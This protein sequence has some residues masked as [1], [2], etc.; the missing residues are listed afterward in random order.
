MSSFG[1]LAEV[2]LVVFLQSVMIRRTR[3]T[4]DQNGPSL[5]IWIHS[6]TPVIDVLK[7]NHRANVTSFSSPTIVLNPWD[8]LDVKDEVAL[9]VRCIDTDHTR[10]YLQAKL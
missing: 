4:L 1:V 9:R 2:I 6:C 7:T 3:S 5:V 8:M 10:V